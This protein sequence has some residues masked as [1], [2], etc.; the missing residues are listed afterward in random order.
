LVDSEEQA[1]TS[2]AFI[3]RPLLGATMAGRYPTFVFYPRSSPPPS[4][5][6]DLSKAFTSARDRIDTSNGQSKESNEV[7]AIVKPDLEKEGFRVESRGGKISR[8]VL[9]GEGGDFELEY[10]VDA[11]HDTQRI[12]VEVEAGRGAKGNAVYRDLIHMS[13]IVDADYA[14]IAVPL[15][16]WFHS[17]SKRIKE[18]AYEKSRKL[19]DAIYSSGRLRF[20]FKGILLVGY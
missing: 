9:F 6:M 5:V 18:P 11:V 17:G 10:R 16:Y 14:V 3:D 7:L 15:E 20:P 19:L 12:V 1:V 13:L 8:P 2:N 4:W